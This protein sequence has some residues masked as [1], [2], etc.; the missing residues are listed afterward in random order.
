MAKKSSSRASRLQKAAETNSK[1]IH[2]TSRESGWAVKREGNKKASRLY[3]TQKSAISEAR[4]LVKSGKASKV[5]I[6]NSKGK[7]RK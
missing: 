1:R 5:I 2:V 6:H 3:S 7:I 4:N